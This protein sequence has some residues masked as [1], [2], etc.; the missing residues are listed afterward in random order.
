MVYMESQ[1]SDSLHSKPHNQQFWLKANKLV[2]ASGCN[3]ADGCK[4]PVPST[5]NISFFEQLLVNY[6][7][8]EIIKYLKYGWPIDVSEVQQLQ[9]KPVNQKGARSNVSKVQEYVNSEID[10]GTVVGPFDNCPLPG[11]RISPLDAIPKR[12]SED[13]RIIMNLSF[14]HDQDSVNAALDK[15]MYLGKQVKLSYPSVWDLVELIKIKGKGSKIFKR[16]LKKFYRQIYMD[17]GFII[18][19]AFQWAKKSIMM[20]C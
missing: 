7:D 5:W 20:W 10:R 2:R 4:I 16:D 12:D 11:T 15:D 18:Y 8:R 13:L 6:P 1:G 17:P 19:W 9:Q 14:P 3:N